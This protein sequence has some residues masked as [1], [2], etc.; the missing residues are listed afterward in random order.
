MTEVDV[1]TRVAIEQL[2]SELLWRLDHGKADT[3]WELYTEDAVS[4]G[5]LGTMDGRDAIKA[6]GQKRAAVTDVVGRHFIGGIRLAWVDG[7]LTGCTAYQT[8][9]DSSPDPLVPASVGEF[10]EEYR[11]VDGRWLIARREIVPVFGGANAAAH[12]A[13]L[14]EGMQR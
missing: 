7:V 1:E 6:W 14:A 12:A 3:T 11:L 13:R 4:T 10:R 2:V 9:R 5:P 8:F